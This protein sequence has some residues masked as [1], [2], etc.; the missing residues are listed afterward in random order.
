[1]SVTDGICSRC[2]KWHEP[3]DCEVDLSKPNPEPNPFCATL[4]F[5]LQYWDGTALAGYE[6]CPRYHYYQ[7]H[8]GWRGLD[9]SVHLT[10]G[11]LVHGA[12]DTFNKALIVNGGDFEEATLDAVAWVLAAAWPADQPHPW[13]GRYVHVWQCNKGVVTNPKGKGPKLRCPEAKGQWPVVDTVPH[14]CPTCGG[15]TFETIAFY[16]ESPAKNH[17]TLIRTVIEYCDFMSRS[18]MRPHVLP[19][20]RVGSELRFI[21]ELP[22]EP[23]PDGSPYY[24]AGTWDGLMELGADELVIPDLKTTQA[25]PTS[26]YF[27]AFNPGIQFITYEWA[28]DGDF[29]GQHPHPKIICLHVQ[30]QNTDVYLYPISH[31]PEQLLEH[32]KDMRYWIG[33]AEQDAREAQR[34]ADAG[35]DPA[36]AYRRNVTAC[37]ACPGAP[38][39]PCNFRDICRMPASERRAYLEGNFRKEPWNPIAIK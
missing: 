10:F 13:G 4:L 6:K 1:M 39:T 8:V 34:L 21:R 30:P 26:A 19:D 17:R 5:Q 36:E 12:A 9:P 3:H 20:G 38:R 32:E 23:S 15:E 14:T 29:P 11:T 37:N 2:H 35:Q 24:V 27:G 7:V 22:G 18:G 28:G 16:P 31:T 25:E 33:R